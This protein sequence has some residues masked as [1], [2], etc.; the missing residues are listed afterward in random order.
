MAGPIG[1]LVVLCHDR[2]GGPQGD[3][4]VVVLV[5]GIQGTAMAWSNLMAELPDTVQAVAPNLRGR[6]GS[7]SPG[8]P[9]AYTLE[10]FADDLA[11]V[12]EHVDAP[13]MLVGWSMGVLVTLAYLR[14]RGLARV[15]G[16]ALVGGTACPNGQCPWFQGTDLISVVG[17]AQSRARALGLRESA[18]PIAVAGAWLAAR[19]ADLRPTLPGI[20]V[21]T[22]VIHGDRDDQCPVD[23]ARAMAA[24]IPGA[25][26]EVLPGGGHQLPSDE[27]AFVAG[28]LIDLHSSIAGI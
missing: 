19:R 18:Q 11:A 21:P 6:A 25:R 20:A 15:R 4:P 26:L 9:S 12:V 13:V 3:E 2:Q 14:D 22:L 8:E 28:K 10:G 27:P 7:A 16:V 1:P 17:E 24:A 5:H 23:H